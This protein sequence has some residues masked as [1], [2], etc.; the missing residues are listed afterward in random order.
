MSTDQ[1]SAEEAH[2]VEI[3]HGDWRDLLRCTAIH[4]AMEWVGVPFSH[5]NRL[6]VAEFLIGDATSA[7]LMRWVPATYV[8]TNDEKLIARRL[9]RSWR[10]SGAIPQP[11]GDKWRESQ[12]SAAQ[13]ED[14]FKTL[15]WLGFLRESGGRHEVAE[16]AESFLRGIGFYFH[17]I[18][19]TG[20]DERFNTS[21]SPD[22]FIM[23]CSPVR[24]RFHRPA[25]LESATAAEGMSEK[26]VAAASSVRRSRSGTLAQT[27]RGLSGATIGS[28]SPRSSAQAPRKL[29]WRLWPSIFRQGER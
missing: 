7:G 20:R 25:Q 21:C 8:L 16:N 2:V 19:L 18:V 24:D 9:V 23:T 29:S 6:Q 4:Q 5:A 27:A 11:Q 26:T 13:V 10:Q 14:A 1:L 3:L 28:R 22:F 12:F 17:E 15:A